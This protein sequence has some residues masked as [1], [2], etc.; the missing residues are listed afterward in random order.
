VLA[1]GRPPSPSPAAGVRPVLR[2]L[3][4]EALDASAD[5]RDQSRSPEDLHAA[6]VERIAT[7]QQERQGRWQKLLSSVMGREVGEGLL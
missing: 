7:I 4:A 1:P 3:P 2:L 6:L 5:A